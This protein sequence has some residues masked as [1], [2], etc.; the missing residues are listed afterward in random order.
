VGDEE[1]E[2]VEE[3]LRLAAREDGLYLAQDRGDVMAIR[4]AAGVVEA[5][6]MGEE[7]QPASI[8]EGVVD[9]L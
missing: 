3:C 2:T 8:P 5:R 6:R 1:L 4:S 9:G 7:W